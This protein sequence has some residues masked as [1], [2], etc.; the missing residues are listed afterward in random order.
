MADEGKLTHLPV[1]AGAS[2]ASDDLFEVLDVSDPDLSADGTN[3]SL[4]RDE[5]AV[6]LQRPTTRTLLTVGSGTYT[7][8]DYCVAI[9]VEVYAAGGGG[10]ACPGSATNGAAASGGSSG[11]YARKYITSPAAT[12]AYT[13]GAKGLGGVAGAND[14]SP[15]ADST[16]DAGGGLVTAKGGPGGLQGALGTT[17][18]ITAAGAQAALS[19]GGSIN[20]AGRQGS[21][22]FRTSATVINAGAGAPSNLGGG[23]IP[24][25]DATGGNASTSGS[26][27][28]GAG[29]SS[30]NTNRAGGDGADGVIIVTEYY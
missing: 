9:M 21:L 28:G 4:T 27:G 18:A 1:L 8:P 5:L 22:G 13:V 26:G 7:T 16:F 11:G 10:G 17:F 19:T 25:D 29:V 12:Y 24:S 15:G 6:A 3:K 14:G 30:V 23:G 20:A 2:V